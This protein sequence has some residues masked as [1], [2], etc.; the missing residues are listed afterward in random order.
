MPATTWHLSSRAERIIRTRWSRAATP[1]AVN[2]TGASISNWHGSAPALVT[3]RGDC[4][5]RVSPPVSLRHVAGTTPFRS[6]TRPTRCRT[7]AR[8][9][10]HYHDASY[11]ICNPGV[12]SATGYVYDAWICIIF[13]VTITVRGIALCRA[14]PRGIS[15]TW[16]CAPCSG[17]SRRGEG[18]IATYAMDDTLPWG[19]RVRVRLA[20]A[21]V[22]VVTPKD[23]ES[24]RHPL[25]HE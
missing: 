12:L 16:S 1:A 13:F 9:G 23:G 21:W 25:R 6:A 4:R 22:L 20:W 11:I 14:F 3:V 2:G 24:L 17:Q 10:G 15:L 5:G 7:S 19:S 18:F 8:Q